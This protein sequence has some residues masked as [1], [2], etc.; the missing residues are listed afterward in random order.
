MRQFPFFLQD[1]Y[2][3]R[4][5]AVRKNTIDQNFRACLVSVPENIYYLAG[6]YREACATI[7]I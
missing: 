3:R 1:E 2:D 6:A 7:V 5:H 4:L